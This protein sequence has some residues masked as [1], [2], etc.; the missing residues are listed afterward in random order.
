MQVD[1]VPDEA[2]S[3]GW[4]EMGNESRGKL[5]ESPMRGACFGNDHRMRRHNSPRLNLALASCWSPCLRLLSPF[6][7]SSVSAAGPVRVRLPSLLPFPFPFH[8]P[9]TLVPSH[10]PNRRS[11]KPSMS[12][13]PTSQS[14]SPNP[15]RPLPTY[16]LDPLSSL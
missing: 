15:H 6:P 16:P 12:S 10:T 7:F 2:R 11:S 5:K 8:S 13:N 4:F 9:S 1:A 14:H 3:E